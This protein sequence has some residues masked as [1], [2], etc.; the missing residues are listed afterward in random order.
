MD[1]KAKIKKKVKRN[2]FSNWFFNHRYKIRMRRTKSRK[3]YLSMIEEGSFSFRN[4][5]IS[6][7]GKEKSGPTME[8]FIGTMWN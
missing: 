3:L 4:E 7:N 6:H 8:Y 5:E 1:P 2:F